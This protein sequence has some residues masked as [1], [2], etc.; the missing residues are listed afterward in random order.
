MKLSRRQA[1]TYSS[2]TRK[3]TVKHLTR[4]DEVLET[5]GCKMGKLL[6]W[7]FKLKTTEHWMRFEARYLPWAA[8]RAASW[9]FWANW[10]CFLRTSLCWC[11]FSSL[12]CG[13]RCRWSS[14]CCMKTLKNDKSHNSWEMTSFE[15]VLLNLNHTSNLKSQTVQC[16][17]GSYTGEIKWT[18]KQ[19][20]SETVNLFPILQIY[21]KQGLNQMFP[22][23]I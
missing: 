13:V 8:W 23:S 22:I 20:L 16:I 10:R 12:G 2:K 9:A 3:A 19:L 7:K 5:N 1:S 18:E 11:F 15:K 4:D 17:S 14:P 21:N 6:Q